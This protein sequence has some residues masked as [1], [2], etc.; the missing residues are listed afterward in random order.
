MMQNLTTM[1][2]IDNFIQI[3]QTTG[4]PPPPSQKIMHARNFFI[5]HFSFKNTRP[6]YENIQMSLS[7]FRCMSKSTTG[8]QC[9]YT[10]LFPR[11][12]SKRMI[13]RRTK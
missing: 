8:E 5:I 1:F 3:L 4:P 2:A 7:S 10:V 13:Y 11:S 6:V 9:K 12:W